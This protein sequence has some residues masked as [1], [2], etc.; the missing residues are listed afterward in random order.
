MSQCAQGVYHGTQAEAAGCMGLCRATGC[1]HCLRSIF[2]AMK[3]RYPSHALVR[4]IERSVLL[5]LP[6]LSHR[7]VDAELLE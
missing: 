2:A 6:R 3:L 4:E 1:L 7:D 5:A